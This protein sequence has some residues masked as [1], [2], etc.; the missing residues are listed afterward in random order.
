VI[1][2]IIGEMPEFDNRPDSQQLA[3]RGYTQIFCTPL[4]SNYTIA[5]SCA[6]FSTK[7]ENGLSADEIHTLRTIQAPLARV[8]EGYVLN[9]STVQVLST[10]VGRDAGS[11]VLEGNILRGHTE[12]I[13]SI[14]LFTDLKNFTE[15]SNCQPASEVIDTLNKFYGIA[16]IAISDNGGEILKFMGDGLLAIFP[17]PDDLAAQMA[18]S[19]SA[20]DSLNQIQ[21]GLDETGRSDIQFRSALHLGDIYYGNIGSVSRLDFTAIGPTVNLAAR[22]L[23]AAS[24]LDEGT[25]CSEDFHRLV[26]QRTS[27]IGEREFKGF[28]EPQLVFRV[29]S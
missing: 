20:I 29:N 17:T 25:V 19:V 28:D 1:D 2:Y 5:D 4:H 9:E 10:Y 12:R 6:S 3:K 18:A 27:K 24:E 14:V 16:E 26:Q 7:Q 21:R 23:D 11:R 8:V 13:P 15:R 22:L